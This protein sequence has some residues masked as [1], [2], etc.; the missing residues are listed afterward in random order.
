METSAS[1][2]SDN[3]DAIN[4]AQTSLAH[5]VERLFGHD[6]CDFDLFEG[7]ALN[8]VNVR[9]IYLSSDIIRGIYEALYVE[10]GEAWR[11]I[12]KTCGHV[13]GKRVSASLQQEVSLLMNA[14]MDELPVEQYVELFEN[15]FSLN[16]WGKLT[17]DLNAAQ[18]HGIVHANL[19]HSLFV[20]A[21]NHLN[22]YVDPMVAGMLQGMFESISGQSL[23]CIEV[24]CAC[25]AHTAKCEFLIS[26]AERIKSI[27]PFV[28]KEATL[29]A[30]I[31]RL[32]NS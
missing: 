7:T 24:T 28:E 8:A 9:M 3:D 1:K 14:G 10:A 26:G 18:Q 6:Y 32:R 12:L 21:L 4:S 11:I 5:V 31:E 15:Y 2:H 30:I 19:T 27:E 23:D 22:D 25:K 17:I 16:G 13:W 29:D 20:H